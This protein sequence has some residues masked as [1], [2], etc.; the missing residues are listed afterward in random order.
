[1]TK[2]VTLVAALNNY[3]LSALCFK[4]VDGMLSLVLVFFSYLD[5]LCFTL[6]EL[7]DSRR[8]IFEGMFIC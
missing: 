5:C 6:L 2:K 4:W 1:M 7:S 3:Y 8:F